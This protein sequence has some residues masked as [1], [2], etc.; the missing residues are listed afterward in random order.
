MEAQTKQIKPPIKI[1]RDIFILSISL[2]FSYKGIHS[3]SWPIKFQTQRVLTSLNMLP[4]V[5]NIFLLLP[6]RFRSG[7][8]NK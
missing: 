2:H 4:M 8:G 5:L 6:L 7:K 3:P 1:T